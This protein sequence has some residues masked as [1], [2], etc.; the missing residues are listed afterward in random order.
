[1]AIAAALCAPLVNAAPRKDEAEPPVP[2]CIPFWCH[3]RFTSQ[4]MT[5]WKD[6]HR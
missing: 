5:P 3:P 6:A 1:L 2:C 4:V